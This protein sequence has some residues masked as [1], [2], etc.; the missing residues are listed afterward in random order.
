[1]PYFAS[2]SHHQR[3]GFT[4]VEMLVV[5]AISS[6][7]AAILFPVFGKARE[8]ARRSSCSS[9]LKQI[10]AA[11]NLYVADNDGTYPGSEMNNRAWPVLLF[12]YA[13]S[14]QIFVCPTSGGV[15]Q[16]DVDPFINGGDGNSNYYA[17]T[18]SLMSGQ[19]ATTVNNLSYSRNLIVKNE[20]RTAGFDNNGKSGFV[21]PSATSAATACNEAA[22]GDAAGTI[23]IVDGMS[24]S[25]N[26]DSMRGILDEAR[27]DHFSDAEDSKVA[28]RHNL[29]FNALYG[30][31]HVKWLPYGSTKAGDWTIQSGD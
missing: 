6:L 22:V 14:G 20:W 15:R 8:G 31:G 4:L 2:R 10:G 13:K 21:L 28:Y 5:I 17:T 16:F 11:M 9:N 27:T 24:S 30:D 7:L 18:N 1:M 26:G 12:S 23:H 25:N 29:G 19:N 3:R